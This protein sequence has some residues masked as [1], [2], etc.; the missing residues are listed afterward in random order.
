MHHSAQMLA[1]RETITPGNANRR[2]SQVSEV[3]RVKESRSNPVKVLG[4]VGFLSWQLCGNEWHFL[5]HHGPVR[6]CAALPVLFYR[7]LIQQRDS[8]PP[9]IPFSL[10]LI[11]QYLQ[12]RLMRECIHE[13]VSEIIIDWRVLSM[14]AWIACV[15]GMA[16]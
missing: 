13:I 4:L 5:T 14:S 9:L 12:K 15:V 7:G 10:F 6:S 11:V 16:I 2:L 3:L 1:T 8:D